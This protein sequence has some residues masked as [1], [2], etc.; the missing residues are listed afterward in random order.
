MKVKIADLKKTLFVRTGLDQD[1]AL[2]LAD[3]IESGVELHPI[4]ITKDGVVVDG[5]H[6]IEAHELC[7]KTEI[8]AEIVEVT[9]GEVGLLAAGYKYNAGGSLPPSRED[10]EHTI[11]LMLDGGAS[12]K[13]I[14]DLLGLPISL[15][16]KYIGMIESKIKRQKLQRAV[17]AVTD[18]GRTAAQAA[19]QHEVDLGSLK[20]SLSGY[21][22]KSKAEGIAEIQHSLT[23]SF[24]SLS[25][26]NAALIRGLLEKLED[27][28]VSA[29]QV[30]EVLDHISDLLKGSTRSVADWRKRFEAKSGTG[31]ASKEATKKA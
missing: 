2:A 23:T 8:E 28:D 11:Q 14:A 19:E 16:R 6:R 10:T 5:R 29:K 27:G 4:N 18:G 12:K 31:K 1:H 7:Q 30:K 21:R 3:L 9:G 26:K 22:K 20:E 13:T 17:A 15:T 25:Q 24:K